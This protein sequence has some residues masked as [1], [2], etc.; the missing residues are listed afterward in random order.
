MPVTLTGCFGRGP[1][2]GALGLRLSGSCANE[3]TAGTLRIVLPG[4]VG[5][6]SGPIGCNGSIGS[7]LLVGGNMLGPFGCS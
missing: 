4:G 6:V 1:G 3:V 7:F 5:I 2:V